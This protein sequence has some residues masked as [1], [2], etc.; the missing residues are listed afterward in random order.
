MP[1]TSPSLESAVSE[2]ARRDPVRLLETE[3]VSKA[4]RRLR[5]EEIGER[6]VYF[7]VTDADSKL[8]GVVPTRRLL[9][10]NPS[11]LVRDVM[12]RPVLSVHGD[13]SFGAALAMLSAN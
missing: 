1:S 6:I 10:S 2:A 8:V 9:L 4:L 3:T 7:Y 12:A 11:T 13:E 5:Q